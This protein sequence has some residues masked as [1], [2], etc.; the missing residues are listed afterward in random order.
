ME[1]MKTGG[2][3]QHLGIPTQVQSVLDK[4]SSVNRTAKQSL[5]SELDETPYTLKL[6]KKLHQMRP[7][8]D[9]ST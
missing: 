2:R 8:A 6:E 9:D 3:L 4:I 1:H 7:S 5:A